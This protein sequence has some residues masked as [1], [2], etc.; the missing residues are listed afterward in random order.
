MKN[1]FKGVYHTVVC[2]CYRPLFWGKWISHIKW[3]P[4]C[5]NVSEHCSQIFNDWKIMA[6]DHG[7]FTVVTVPSLF[8]L[9][10]F[11]EVKRKENWELT[12]LSVIIGKYHLVDQ[13]QRFLHI[14][15]NWEN[16]QMMVFWALIL[17][18]ENK[19]WY[20]GC[21]ESIL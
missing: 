8:Q 18:K 15:D 1:V 4:Q 7:S 9:F 19:F 11:P 16:C 21:K 14:F 20:L 5:N 6:W 10:L 3:I 13:Q 17:G 12:I 2:L